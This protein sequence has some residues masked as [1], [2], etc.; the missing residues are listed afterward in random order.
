MTYIPA[1]ERELRPRLEELRRKLGEP[2]PERPAAV[3]A[4]EPTPLERELFAEVGRVVREYE[5]SPEGQAELAAV[6]G[7]SIE[8]IASFLRTFAT[9][10]RFA[11]TFELLAEHRALPDDEKTYYINAM[12]AGLNASVGFILEADMQLGIA[13]DVQNPENYSE[14][15]IYLSGSIW[16]G[17]DGIAFGGI[18]IGFWTVKPMG[19]AGFC[20]S[21]AIEGAVVGGASAEVSFTVLPPALLGVTLTVI[22]GGGEG[23]V[24]GAS[25]TIVWQH[26]WV[27]QPPAAHYMILETITC[28]D[29]SGHTGGK[30]E[31]FFRFTID[32]RATYRYPSQ[33]QYSMDSGWVWNP[34]RSMRFNESVK[35]ELFDNDDVGDDS[36]GYT[37]Y[38]PDNTFSPWVP[39]TGDNASYTLQAVLDPIWKSWTYAGAINDVDTTSSSPAACEFNGALHVFWL[40][41]NG[42]GA[43]FHSASPNGQAPWP[44]GQRINSVDTTPAAPAACA[45]QGQLYVFWK[46]GNGQ[47][48]CSAS[49][50]ESVWPNGTSL[51]SY[52]TLTAP[53]ACVFNDTLYVFWVDAS[54]QVIHYCTLAAG[55]Q[56]WSSPMTVTGSWTAQ[57]VGACTFDGWL[58]LFWQGGNQKIYWSRSQTGQG[59]QTPQTVNDGVSTPTGPSACVADG[60]QWVFWTSTNDHNVLWSGSKQG[61]TWSYNQDV[62]PGG[63]TGETTVAPAAAV[64]QDAPLVFWKNSAGQIVFAR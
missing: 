47:I 6:R 1:L 54:T 58:Y 17:E 39:V 53:T 36:L 32:G 20:F 44:N 19:L 48:Y 55:S 34:G 52:G 2:P 10:P 62:A 35:V 23:I 13:F 29:T 50:G 40:A 7:K 14:D 38:Y 30:D 57:P 4:L 24:G 3:P 42:S 61:A 15:V 64:Y 63:T 33:G 18:A 37:T 28:N 43:I 9:G 41:S 31:L 46:G 21:A 49:D 11:R 27:Y 56:T 12:S 51:G 26:P 25:Y 8:E 16:V 60:V 45:F 59:W 22:T 5:A